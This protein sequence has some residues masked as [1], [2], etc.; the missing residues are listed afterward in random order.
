MTITEF[1][2]RQDL[3]E[4][5]AENL[6]RM[7]EDRYWQDIISEIADGFVYVY[8]L[9]RVQQWLAVGCPDVDDP[10][11]VEGVTDVSQIIAVAV[12]EWAL[13]ELCEMARDAG[14]D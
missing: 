2:M 12:F 7:R 10:G 4:R 14:L 8:T 6:E 9:E 11:L 3:T 1:D 5:F 13:A